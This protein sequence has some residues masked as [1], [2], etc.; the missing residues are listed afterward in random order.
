MNKYI[1][2]GINKSFYGFLILL[3]D[4]FPIEIIRSMLKTGRNTLILQLTGDRGAQTQGSLTIRIS[5]GI[6]IYGSIITTLCIL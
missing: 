6:Y 4:K 1:D 3:A 2:F 5:K